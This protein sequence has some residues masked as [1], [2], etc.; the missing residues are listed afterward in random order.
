MI[1]SM[2]PYAGWVFTLVFTPLLTVFSARYYTI[3][4]DKAAP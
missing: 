2:I 4:Y 3:L 1:L